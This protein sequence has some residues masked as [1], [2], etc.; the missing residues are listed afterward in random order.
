MLI[1][2]KWEEFSRLFGPSGR[3]FYVHKEF[4][5]K[6]SIWRMFQTLWQKIKARV[7]FILH[8]VILKRSEEWRD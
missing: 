2:E 6:I 8:Y 4:K 7:E 3:K 5:F 1:L